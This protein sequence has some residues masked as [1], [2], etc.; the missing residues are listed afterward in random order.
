MFTL[1]KW[2]SFTQ[3]K[4]FFLLTGFFLLLLPYPGTG[5]NYDVNMNVYFKHLGYVLFRQS[6]GSQILWEK[7]NNISKFLV[8]VHQ[9]IWKC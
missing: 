2:E 8:T 3:Y 1:K 7:E 9:I 4:S 6:L 5:W